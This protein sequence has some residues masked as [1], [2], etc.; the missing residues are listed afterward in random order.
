ML[1][2][3]FKVD[4]SNVE[5]KGEEMITKYDYHTSHVVAG[6]E[7]IKIV[8]ETKKL[9]FKT[10]LHVP[11]TGVM[12][13]GW[14]GNN[15]TTLTSGVLANKKKLVWDT[16]RG[17]VKA[18]YHGSLT[19]CGTTYLGQDEKGTTYVA[20]F[21]ALLPMVDP[22]NLVIGGWDINDMDIYH[23]A[24]RALVMEPVML[25]MLKD[26]L[27]KMKPL[28]AVFDLDFVA[29]N[30]K[31]RANNVIPGTKWEQLETVRKQMRDFKEQNKLEKVIILWTANTERYCDVQE[32]VH[33]TPEQLLDAIKNNHAEIA[34][35]QIYAVAAI[36][37]HI[38]Y[39]NGSPQNTFVPGLIQL[40]EREGVAIMGDDFKT[41]QTK[42]KSVMADF[43]I[44]SG[45]KLTA[46]VSY[47]HLGNNDGLNLDFDLCFRSKQISKSSVIDDMV[48]Y[49]PILYPN[50]EHPDHV[51]VIKYVP[52][53]GDSKRALDE[54]DSDIF[55]G[56]KNIISVHNTCEDSLLAA[57]LML[58]LILLMELFTRVQ[59][60]DETMKEFSHMNSVYSVLSFLLKAPRTPTGTPVINSLF[61]QRACMENILRAT[62]GLQ[63]LN[64]MHLEW[65]MP[66]Q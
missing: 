57:P 65:K 51:V 39:I 49:N 35:S 12:L 8:P 13:V 43:L 52:S 27:E 45:L 37:E 58:D 56:G 3:E 16:K 47:N 15:G 22:D 53:V 50:G 61:Q 42:F 41:G 36:L 32:G 66:K 64:N 5:I 2:N 25:N 24:K 59:L 21:K 26:D 30:Q 28:P 6:P 33:M 19:Q 17:E 18:N 46:V 9:E 38:P 40:A 20:P 7:G 1:A 10:D 11:K 34:P 48:G 14:G 60:K 44:S 63:P 29:P 54:Y 4:S 55:C 23:A 62:R 31:E